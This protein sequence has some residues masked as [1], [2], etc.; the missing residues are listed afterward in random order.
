VTASSGEKTTIRQQT[1]LISRQ[2]TR[3]SF[4]FEDSATS[5]TARRVTRDATGT[6][7]FVTRTNDFVTGADD[8]G[9]RIRFHHFGTKGFFHP[10]AL[11]GRDESRATGRAALKAS[12][13]TDANT[14]AAR[15]FPTI[16]DT[17]Y[18][19]TATGINIYGAPREWHT[20]AAQYGYQ[21]SDKPVTGGV[22]CFEGGAYGTSETYGFAGVVA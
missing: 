2:S 1:H 21:V 14:T 7:D 4:H 3:Q 6:G 20:L 12:H 5:R 15:T 10:S 9:T 19:R 13:E 11:S 8:F 18:V 17:S 22:I 16:M